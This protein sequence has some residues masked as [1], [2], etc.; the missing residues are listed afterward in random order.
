MRENMRAG[1]RLHS[2]VQKTGRGRTLYV[3]H[4]YYTVFPSL[5]EY[6]YPQELHRGRN[7]LR[8]QLDLAPALGGL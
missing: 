8:L 3:T 6:L 2:D 7:A 1:S 5:L 4:V